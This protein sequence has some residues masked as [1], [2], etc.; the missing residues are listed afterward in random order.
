MEMRDEVLS[1]VV[2]QVMDASGYKASDLEY[3]EIQLENEQLD[4]ESAYR[5][6]IGMPFHLQL[7]TTL[8]LEFQ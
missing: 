7:L 2:A 5:V 3:F 1:G 6:G 8:G 4:V